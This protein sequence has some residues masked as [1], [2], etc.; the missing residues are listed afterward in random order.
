MA[1]LKY[2]TFNIKV[3]YLNIKNR[4]LHRSSDLYNL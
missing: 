3:K 1:S 2:L 4:K